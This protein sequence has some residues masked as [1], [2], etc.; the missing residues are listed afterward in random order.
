MKL[1]LDQIAW[2]HEMHKKVA[3]CVGK[4]F[5]TKFRWDKEGNL[6]PPS[7]LGEL[8]PIINVVRFTDKVCTMLGLTLKDGDGA[9]LPVFN[10]TGNTIM[11]IKDYHMLEKE[12]RCV[13]ALSGQCLPWYI[14]EREDGVVYKFGT[15]DTLKLIG[16]FF[17]E[18]LIFVN[19]TSVQDLFTMMGENPGMLTVLL[20][21]INQARLDKLTSMEI[22]PSH[23]L[24][25]R[26]LP[27][28]KSIS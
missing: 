18:E 27:H 5:Q 19:C 1:K 7:D 12:I 24:T 14:K 20:L 11:M 26:P 22:T 21:E 10:Y 28:R 25:K 6:D 16:G 23:P 9:R 15:T 3:I 17:A 8:W 4:D 2:F 13:K